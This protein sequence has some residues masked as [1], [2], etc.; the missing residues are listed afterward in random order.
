MGTLTG[1]ETLHAA[2]TRRLPEAHVTVEAPPEPSGSWWVDIQ[3]AGKIAS[4]EWRPGHG[5][6]VA[7]VDAVY[8][9]GPERV[10]DDVTATAEYIAEQLL[11]PAA[12]SSGPVLAKH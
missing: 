2:V 3:Y 4:V 7:G 11:Q 8:G 5:F 10:F 6:G 1:I 12:A 9:E